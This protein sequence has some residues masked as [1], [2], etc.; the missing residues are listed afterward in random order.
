MFEYSNEKG[1]LYV[2]KLVGLY[3]GTDF[4]TLELQDNKIVLED[5]D[6]KRVIS[7]KSFKDFCVQRQRDYALVSTILADMSYNY[8]FG[9]GKTLDI[10]ASIFDSTSL[11]D[12][13]NQSEPIILT[14]Y[15]D[16]LF[17]SHDVE[18]YDGEIEYLRSISKEETK[19]HPY[20]V[21]NPKLSLS[22]IDTIF[23][24]N[25]VD[26]KQAL[27]LLRHCIEKGTFFVSGVVTNVYDRFAK[28]R[29]STY[30]QIVSAMEE[31]G[32][33]F[34]QTCYDT[35]GSVIRLIHNFD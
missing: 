18:T 21:S 23:Y 2:I 31:K 17:F 7:S 10:D 9:F 13:F 1:L 29:I 3:L 32:I 26:Y 5:E 8:E 22:D 14:R 4:N 11:L 20:I 19:I 28:E 16:P 30:E 24:L 12:D 34:N 15:N 33:T 35:C 6:L 25:D 27:V